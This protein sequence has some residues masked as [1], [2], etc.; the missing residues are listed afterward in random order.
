LL[1]SDGMLQFAIASHESHEEI[2]IQKYKVVS[3]YSN[4]PEKYISL[5]EKYSLKETGNIV[6]PWNT[7]SREYPGE[8]SKICID[9]LD[10]YSVADILKSQGMYRAKIIEE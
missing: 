8:C 3:I 10:V 6:T 9:G 5:L 4:T 2:F 1:F 7:F